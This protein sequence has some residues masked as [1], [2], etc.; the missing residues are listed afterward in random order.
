MLL[1]SSGRVSPQAGLQGQTSST[2]VECRPA[3]AHGRWRI[4]RS[5]VQ[6]TPADQREHEQRVGYATTKGPWVALA[7]TPHELLP[8][9]GAYSYGHHHLAL[10]SLCAFPPQPRHEPVRTV[11]ACPAGTAGTSGLGHSRCISSL[12]TASHTGVT[13]TMT[14]AQRECG[15]VT[16]VGAPARRPPG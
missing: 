8:S 2:S 16:A 5:S 14:A 13:P 3:T 9:R 10:S 6:S 1:S 7:G 4:W 12:E 15:W 11:C